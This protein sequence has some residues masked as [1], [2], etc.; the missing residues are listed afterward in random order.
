MVN[1]QYYQIGSEFARAYYGKMSNS[2]VNVAFELFNQN[3]ICTINTEELRGSYNWLL[4][5]TKDGI[6]RFEYCNLSVTYQPLANYEIL[7]SVQGSMKALS[8]WGQYSGNWLR[9][10][11]TFVLE[12]N[13]N[14]Y[15]IRNYILK[16]N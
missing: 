16:F 5:M 1:H 6:S 11:E 4:K 9:F 10:N 3:A 12:K 15:S 14:K 7:V 2:G 13:G 8:L